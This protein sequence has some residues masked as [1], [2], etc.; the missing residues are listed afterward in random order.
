MMNLRLHAYSFQRPAWSTGLL[1][2]A[3]FICGIVSAI[4]IWRGGEK[5]KRTKEVE[6]RLSMALALETHPNELAVV[7]DKVIYKSS[8]NEQAPNSP[9]YRQEQNGQDNGQ[10]PRPQY[11][12]VAATVE[13]VNG[14]ERDTPSIYIE[15][16]MFIPRNVPR[17]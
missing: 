17:R 10:S 14:G 8:A 9:D 15:D 16:K 3:S 13:H 6:E 12:G 2:P 7:D 5:T 4:L 1:I 11:E